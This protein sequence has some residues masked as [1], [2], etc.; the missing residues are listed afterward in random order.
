[1]ARRLLFA[2]AGLLPLAAP[3]RAETLRTTRP[4]AVTVVPATRGI[5]AETLTVTGTVVPREEVLVSPQIEG[6]AI[7]QVLADEGDRVSGGQVLARLSREM[8][9]TQLAQN[10][11]QSARAVAAISQAQSA[12]AE[13]QATRVQADAAFVRARELLATG[14]GSRENFENRQAA[15]GVAAARLTA[16]QDLLAVAQADR[17]L[18]AAQREELAVKIART[19]VRTP[20]AGIVSRRVAHLGA[21]VMG[22]GDPLFRVI[23]DGAVE[24]EADVPEALLA[25]LAPGQPAN[26]TL[27]GRNATLPGRVRLV[28]PEVGKLTRLGHV[29]IAIDGT[30][31][32][33]GGFARASVETARRD[34]VQVPLSAVLFE[35]EGARVQV[36]HDGTVETRPVSVGLRSL[37]RAE[38]VQGLAEGEQVVSVSGTFVR[39]GD[40]VTPVPRADAAAR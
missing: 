37:G 17:A 7:T 39:E 36:V 8:L 26:L 4:P 29:R 23:E 27:P 12:I 9:E 38:I 6:L 1:M 35:P 15:A 33:V 11:A 25:R 13:A 34:C 19:D 10:A 2:V 31:I 5:M 32:P 18:A 16:A 28:S 22:A 21:V 24:L 30:G 40:E 20:V 14:S 3:L